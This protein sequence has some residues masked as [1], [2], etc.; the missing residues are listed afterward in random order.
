MLEKLIICK[1]ATCIIMSRTCFVFI[2][3]V[4]QISRAKLLGLLKNFFFPSLR[5]IKVNMDGAAN[6]PLGFSG[7]GGVFRTNRV[8]IKGC[9]AFSLINVHVYEAEL[10]AIVFAIDFA[11][12]IKWEHLWLEKDS[13]YIVSLL[14]SRCLEVLWHFR[15][16]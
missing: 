14:A 10:W 1:R 5:W 13:T 16:H 9:Y 2:G 6:G 12:Q 4:L 15:A 3:L 7:C 8:F 11:C